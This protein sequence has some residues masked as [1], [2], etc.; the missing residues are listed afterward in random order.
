MCV[1]ANLSINTLKEQLKA[2]G[3]GIDYVLVSSTSSSSGGT[4]GKGGGVAAAAH[5]G[6]SHELG[7]GGSS[8]MLVYADV[9]HIVMQQGTASTTCW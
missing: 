5:G 9:S 6:S 1:T 3:R 4:R 7:G 8:L 2:A